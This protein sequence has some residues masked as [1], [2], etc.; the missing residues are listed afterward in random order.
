MDDF[1]SFFKELNGEFAVS[2]E[3]NDF[4][5][6][7]TDYT[8]SFP[9]FFC[10]KDRELVIS[11]TPESLLNIIKDPK[12]SEIA[13]R[14]LRISGST[15]GNRTLYEDI[16]TLGAGEL[17]Y[18]DKK[19]RSTSIIE[20][21]DFDSAE[22]SNQST[23]SLF[24]EMTKTY[25]AAI[26][27]T[28]DPYEGRQIVIPLGSGWW[29]RVLVRN[30]YDL[31]YKNVLCYTYGKKD[32]IEIEK[33]REIAKH[34]GFSWHVTNYDPNTWYRWFTGPDYKKYKTYAAQFVTVPNIREYLAVKDLNEKGIISKD[35]IFINVCFT[36][37]MRGDLLSKYFLD[38]DIPENNLKYE[39][40]REIGSNISWT[41][42]D[43]QLKD[44]YIDD[45]FQKVRKDNDYKDKTQLWK[46][47]YAYWKER[48]AK[49]LSSSR[50]CYEI[51]GYM[52]RNIQNERTILDF[53]SKVDPNIR[54]KHTLQNMYDEKYNKELLDKLNFKIPIQKTIQ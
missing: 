19:N 39:I 34:Y 50:R 20:Y 45:I 31:G 52:W 29:E 10:K 17:I 13:V 36:G 18:F 14:E 49:H 1:V 23:E 3:T 51:F 32:S 33:S 9:L 6:G 11:D 48:A 40:L 54:Y 27:K 38:E 37:V 7:A 21:M 44:K 22:R 12:V 2:I 28:L 46:F 53:W 4:I 15:F 43:I 5:L 35:A 26:K 41:A 47:K 42:K 8:R 24:E 16:E 30:I 25:R